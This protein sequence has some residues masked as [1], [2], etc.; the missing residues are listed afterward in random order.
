MGKKKGKM[1]KCTPNQIMPLNTNVDSQEYVEKKEKWEMFQM[2]FQVGITCLA[3]HREREQGKLELT[4]STRDLL[5]HCLDLRRIVAASIVLER[6]DRASL[7]FSLTLQSTSAP[8][9]NPPC[10]I[11][12]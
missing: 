10:T 7:D 6:I 5:V 11:I 2:D 1:D 4:E 9:D 12:A 8:C 3:P